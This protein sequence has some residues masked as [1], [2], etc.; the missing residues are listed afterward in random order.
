MTFE[1][2]LIFYVNILN[3]KC[4]NIIDY[5]TKFLLLLSVESSCILSFTFLAVTYFLITT[6]KKRATSGTY[7]PSRQEM[8]GTRVELGNVWKLPPTERLI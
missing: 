1:K 8:T 7:S 4:Y 5:L 6:R 2:L 3:F